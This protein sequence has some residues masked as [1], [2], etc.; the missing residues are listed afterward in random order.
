MLWKMRRVL[1]ALPLALFGLLLA[2]G[3]AAWAQ[4]SDDRSVAWRRYDVRMEVRQDGSLLVTETQEVAFRGSFQRAFRT[5]PT[6]RTSGISSVAVAEVTGGRRVDYSRGSSRANTYT[7]SMGEDGLTINWQFSPTTNASR[8]WEVSYVVAGALRIYDQG[9]QLQWKAVYA[10]RPGP[11]EASSLTVVLPAPVAADAL[12]TAHYRFRTGDTFGAEREA[13]SGQRLDDRT[14]RFDVGSLPAGTGAEVR[15]QFP[16]GIVAATPP[17]WQ[18][19]ADAADR[20]AQTIAPIAAFLAL[21]LSLA[22]LF[23]GGLLLLLRW[24]VRG[25]DPGVGKVAPV[26]DQPPSDLP[27]PLAG[28]L[29]DERADVQD[30]VAALA[31]LGERGVVAIRDVEDPSLLGS[32]HDVEV[33]LLRSPAGPTL[34]SYE[35][36]LLAG[37]F[38]S[39]ARTGDKVRLSAIRLRF[40]SVI[41][42]LQAQLHQAVAAQGLFPRDPERTR[43]NARRM[44]VTLVVG[45]IMLAFLG[46]AAFGGISEIAWLPGTALAVVGAA[47][48]ATAR[49][50]PARTRQGAL[51]AARWR[52]FQRYL[53]EAD[54]DS[55]PDSAAMHRYLPY[56]IALG[57]DRDWL[58]KI[59]SVGAPAPA[60]VG[61]RV[62]RPGGGVVILPG[63]WGGGPWVGGGHAGGPTAGS[64]GM[65]GG[66]GAPGVPNP[67]GWSDALADI[68]NSASEGLARGGGSGGWSGGGF[69]GGG[70][71][72]GGSGGFS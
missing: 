33:E 4:Q 6:D 64:G 18:A 25:R 37:L 14:V 61:G 45:G 60:W 52:A 17:P 63:G 69:G 70:G 43:R 15:V 57:A 68:L 1:V 47:M 42:V 44:G 62:G 50:M 35:R 71:G 39:S 29:V 10:D 3:P 2:L 67:S 34:H 8:T 11:V 72:G 24:L 51:E 40:T 36:T 27:A 38:G 19:Q 46:T 7:T 30:A 49:G 56:A 16:H 65:D 31:D 55:T 66:F 12:R 48:M 20:I 28:T 54:A 59:E 26:L 5:I 9:D 32:K 23:G 13:G 53:H 58:H 21:L 41:P 22:I